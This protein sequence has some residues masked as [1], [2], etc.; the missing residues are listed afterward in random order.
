MD[1]SEAGPPEPVGR[2]GGTEE[3]PV[4]ARS[5]VVAGGTLGC[6]AGAAPTAPAGPMSPADAISC[7]YCGHAGAVREFLSLASPSRPARVVV[8]V[9][10]G[11]RG[12]RIHGAPR[13]P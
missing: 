9:V 3:I 13:T 4:A 5:T 10:A 8:R 6:P 12:V 1:G 11:G 2:P 7:G